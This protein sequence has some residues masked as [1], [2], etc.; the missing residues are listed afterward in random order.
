[1]AADVNDVFGLTH[2]RVTN[3]SSAYHVLSLLCNRK[4]MN[5]DLVAAIKGTTVL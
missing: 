1:M 4:W 5:S 2:T 3:A